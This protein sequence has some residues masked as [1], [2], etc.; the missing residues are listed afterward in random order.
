MVKEDWAPSLHP[1]SGP[2]PRW[3]LLESF[4]SLVPFRL[5]LRGQAN[6][7]FHSSC[8]NVLVSLP[9]PFCFPSRRFHLLLRFPSRPCCSLCD[10]HHRRSS[11]PP[12]PPLALTTFE[13]RKEKDEEKER[14]ALL[15]IFP[16]TRPRN[17][18]PRRQLI[19]LP[20]SRFPFHGNRSL[21]TSATRRLLS[22]R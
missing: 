19:S 20:G 5:H 7:S 22:A 17:E 9:L 18:P 11:P 21:D 1:E 15:W 4:S 3:F 13:A 2:R 6:L 16:L 14:V 8:F 10:P 12:P